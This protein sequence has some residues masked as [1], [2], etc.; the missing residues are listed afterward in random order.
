MK[1]K[2]GEEAGGRRGGAETLR[3]TSQ[4]NTFLSYLVV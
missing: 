4:E 1:K 2:R 3:G